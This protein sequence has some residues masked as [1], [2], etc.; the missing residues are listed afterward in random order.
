MTGGKSD[1]A[2]FSGPVSVS[3]SNFSEKDKD[4]SNNG[5]SS[6]QDES[7]ST[8][9]LKEELE[10]RVFMMVVCI[11]LKVEEVIVALFFAGR[12]LGLF[13][14]CVVAPPMRNHDHK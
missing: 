5:S 6:L 3:A 2:I 14:R 11:D 4:N 12:L 7:S 1:Q 9:S 10:K 13:E 8:S